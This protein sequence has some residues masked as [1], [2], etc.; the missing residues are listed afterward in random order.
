VDRPEPRGKLMARPTH[1]N[2]QVPSHESLMQALV[3]E[4]QCLA[5]LRAETALAQAR[6]EAL[7]AE[8][9]SV[10]GKHPVRVQSP[11]LPPTPMPTSS[12]EKVA[13]FRQLFRGREDVFPVRWTNSKR[14][15]SGYH[16][17]ARI[18]LSL[19]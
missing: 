5:R 11:A 1:S 2:L 6:I 4:E 9:A 19:T 13:L 14:G 16:P 7:K 18:S 10:S 8:L 12:V 15:R 17:P 3:Q